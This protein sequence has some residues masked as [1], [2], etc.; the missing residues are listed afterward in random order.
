VPVSV[1]VGGQYGSEGKGKVAHHL[2]EHLPASAV[3]RVGGPNSGHTIVVNGER[4][5]LR[6]LPVSAVIPGCRSILG[7]GSYI[8]VDLLLEEV[9]RYKVGP[10]SLLIDRHAVV[11]TPGDRTNEERAGLRDHIGSTCSGTGSSVQRRIGRLADV[12]VESAGIMELRPYIRDAP[13]RMRQ[14]L[15]AGDRLIV[16]GTQ[17][18][19][20]SVLHAPDYP[21]AT[22]RDTT[23]A[24]A[25]SEAGLSP[26]D[27][28]QII[29]V[30]R[31]HPIRVAGNSGPFGGEEIDWETVTRESGTPGRLLEHTTVTQRVRRVAR[32]DPGLVRHAIAVNDPTH[33]ALNHVDYVDHSCFG[34]E[35]LSRKAGVFVNQVE[36]AIGRTV[37]YVGTSPEMVVPNS[38][39]A[40]AAA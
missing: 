25:V 30:I 5:V 20:L 3:V 40:T 11:I 33:I 9:E 4:H 13:L 2:A 6:Q 10:E 35:T 38:Q 37:N 16:E 28:D 29:L 12:T 14:M 21:F 39:R 19:G 34:S 32:F 23:A 31:A 15:Q 24:G 26:R 1:V 17:G 7:P 27:V 36:L 8:D 18:F 22:S